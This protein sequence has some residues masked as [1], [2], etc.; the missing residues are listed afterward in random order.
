MLPCARIT[1][2]RFKGTFSALASKNKALAPPAT[3]GCKRSHYH[4]SARACWPK[5]LIRTTPAV[6]GKITFNTEPHGCS[7]PRQSRGFLPPRRMG[8]LE[9]AL[10]LAWLGLRGPLLVGHWRG[11]GFG[12]MVA[13]VHSAGRHVGGQPTARAVP[14]CAIFQS[15]PWWRKT[16]PTHCTMPAP[17][18]RVGGSACGWPRIGSTTTVSTTCSPKSRAGTC[19]WRT[20]GCVKKG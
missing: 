7:T 8:M 19:P 4:A 15:M 2:I 12:R 13:V 10:K 6:V 20:V 18:W 17:R 5:G 1:S 3:C 11:H 9:P 14:V 16:S